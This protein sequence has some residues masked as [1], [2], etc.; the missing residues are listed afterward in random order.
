MAVEDLGLDDARL[1]ELLRLADRATQRRDKVICVPAAT[2]SAL[3]VEVQQ[4]RAL[5]RNVV[6]VSR[7]S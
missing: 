4:S 7:A 3:V 2:L 6:Q 1:V 5:L